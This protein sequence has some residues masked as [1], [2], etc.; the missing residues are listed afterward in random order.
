M[1]YKAFVVLLM[2]LPCICFAIL[3]GVSR[4]LSS[5]SSSDCRTCVDN[6]SLNWCTNSGNEPEIGECCSSGDST[7]YCSGSSYVCSNSSKISGDNAELMLCPIDTGYCGTRV[8]YFGDLGTAT[9]IQVSD[10]PSNSL[11]AYRIYTSGDSVGNV[12]IA[13]SE[14]SSGSITVLRGKKNENEYI[15]SRHMVKGN[16]KNFTMNEDNNVYIVFVPSAVSNNATIRLTSYRGPLT[17]AEVVAILA[18]VGSILFC[19]FL[20]IGIVLWKCVFKK[21]KNQGHVHHPTPPPAPTIPA[22]PPIIEAPPPMQPSIIETSQRFPPPDPIYD[23]PVYGHPAAFPSQPGPL[24]GQPQY[25]DAGMGSMNPYLMAPDVSLPPITAPMGPGGDPSAP[26]S[27]P[28][29]V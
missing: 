29:V 3:P 13:V 5:S 9:P 26:V 15:Y 17:T 19:C 7:G 1:L 21:R 27:K 24:Y 25:V 8:R 16:S 12:E 2:C 20:G 6:N 14:L 23:Q 4:Y 22:P 18:I 11:C 10:V 28:K